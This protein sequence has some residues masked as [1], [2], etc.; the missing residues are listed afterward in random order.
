MVRLLRRSPIDCSCR[1][2]MS[3]T[4][5]PATRSRA[6]ERRP[7]GEMAAEHSV[8]AAPEVT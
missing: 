7:E 2:P 6:R 5:L 3:K 1:S 8:A 4:S